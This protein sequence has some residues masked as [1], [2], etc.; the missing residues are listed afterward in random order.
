MTKWK[1]EM[2]LNLSF[3]VLYSVIP[4]TLF[5]HSKHFILSFRALYSVIPS[6]AEESFYSY[7]FKIFR[8]AQDD[9]QAVI[10][11]VAKESLERSGSGAG[12]PPTNSEFRTPNSELIL[13]FQALYSVIPSVVEESFYSYLFKIFRQAQDDKQAVIPS[14]AEE[15]L[16]FYLIPIR[17]FLFYQ[18]IFLFS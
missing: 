8:Q 10:P 9:K 11:S 16:Q 18:P 17:I 5:C 4:S 1:V 7:L 3:Q 13:S 6:V 2:T 12:V 14:V 15:S